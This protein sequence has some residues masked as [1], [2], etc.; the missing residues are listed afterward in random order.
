MVADADKE[1]ALIK[2][3]NPFHAVRKYSLLVAP[4]RE[5]ILFSVSND[6]V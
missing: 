3:F 1:L 4:V 2:V 5:Y 6:T